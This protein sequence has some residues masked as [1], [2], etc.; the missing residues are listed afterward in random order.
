MS[1]PGKKLAQHYTYNNYKRPIK[2]A[3]TALCWGKI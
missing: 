2:K 1:F 3:V